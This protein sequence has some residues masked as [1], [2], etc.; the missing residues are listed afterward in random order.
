MKTGI[1]IFAHG[2]R[3]EGA[4]ES[5]RS[6]AADMASS[7]GYEFV[8]AAFLDLASPDLGAAVEGLLRRGADRIVVIPY[9]LTPGTHLDRDLPRLVADIASVHPTV[10]IEVT[11][12]L[13]GHPALREILLE[14]ARQA[15]QC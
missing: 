10:P 11:E 4:N 14:R 6:V 1:V 5:V 3:I 8:E 13:D 12:P 7:G 15:L 9:F 2:S